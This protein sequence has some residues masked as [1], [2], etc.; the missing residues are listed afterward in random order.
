ML[1]NILKY[2]IPIG[3]DANFVADHT[4]NVGSNIFVVKER[5]ARFV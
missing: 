2:D 3:E 4:G 5:S 1:T